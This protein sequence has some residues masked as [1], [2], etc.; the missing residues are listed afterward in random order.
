MAIPE[1]KLSPDDKATLEALEA[2]FVDLEREI[3]KAE[4]AEL[5]AAPELRQ[6]FEKVKRQRELML[7]VYG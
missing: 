1:I 3:A 7:K 6:N 2:D 4:A 5:D